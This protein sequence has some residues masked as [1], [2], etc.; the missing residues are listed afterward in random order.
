MRRLRNPLTSTGLLPLRPQQA[1]SRPA[2]KR[3][4]ATPEA[5]NSVGLGRAVV[6][7]TASIDLALNTSARLWTTTLWPTGSAC[8][9]RVGPCNP[10]SPSTACDKS[11]RW[12]PVG[13][14]VRSRELDGLT[15]QAKPLHSGSQ[16]A[17]GQRVGRHGCYRGASPARVR[18]LSSTSGPPACGLVAAPIGPDTPRI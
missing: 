6:R 12:G 1:R 5:L 7:L 2:R 16:G 15:A 13:E 11:R 17:G 14:S 9:W 8:S 3:P 18:R 4:E 10:P